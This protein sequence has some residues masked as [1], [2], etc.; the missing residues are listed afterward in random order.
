MDRG[1]AALFGAIV[2]VGLGPAMWLG[3]RLGAVDTAPVPPPA[4]G[5][6]TAGPEQ[7]VGGSGAGDSPLGEATNK[8]R[9]HTTVLRLSTSPSAREHTRTAAPKPSHTTTSPTVSASPSG[10]GGPT[11]PPTESTGGPTTPPTGPTTP[12]TD[13]PDP[14]PTTTPG[15]DVSA[16]PAGGIVAD[17]PIA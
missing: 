3:V 13:A 16:N 5:E 9:P 11:S 4:V 7:L 15:L 17:G 2:A 12:P 10:S 1:P 8:A 6:H 14:P